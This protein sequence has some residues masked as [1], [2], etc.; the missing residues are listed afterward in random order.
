MDAPDTKCYQQYQDVDAACNSWQNSDG[1]SAFK[2]IATGVLGCMGLGEVY[3][4]I[5][6]RS[7]A[8]DYMTVSSNMLK[9]WGDHMSDV[10]SKMGAEVDKLKDDRDEY[11]FKLL[12]A[13][14]Q[15]YYSSSQLAIEI[16]KTD[17]STNRFLI[18]IIFAFL[19]IIIWDRLSS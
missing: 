12:N 17:V 4:E 10:A 3:D 18:Y 8:S 11:R 13:I 15:K 19:I 16:L 2:G 5:A 9:C 1:W 6:G 7:G 14:V